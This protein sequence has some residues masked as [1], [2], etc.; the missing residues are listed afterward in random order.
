MFPQLVAGPIVRYHTVADQ[1]QHRTHTIP[2]FAAGAQLFMIGFAKKVLLA[3]NAAYLADR[4]F[5]LAS[6]DHLASPGLLGAWTGISA[7]AVQIYFDFSGYS[8]MA[9]GLGL[10]LGFRFPKNFD[11]P[12]KSCSVTET[13]Q[14]WHIS[15]SSWLRD[16]LYIPLGGNRH[17]ELRTYG[18]LVLTMLLGGLWHGALWTKVMWGAYNGILLASERLSGRRPVYH[19]LPRPARMAMTFLIW[20]VGLTIFR[21]ESLDS[22][23][24]V[25]AGM[26]G[27]AG[28]GVWLTC[29]LHTEFAYAALLLGL[30]IAFAAPQS[31]DIVRRYRTSSMLWINAAFVLALLQVMSRSHSP[32][33][34]FQF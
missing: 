34:Y 20:L 19:R 8:D 4:V 26:V 33:I 3:D 25:Y 29:A 1:I 10:M 9:I 24:S 15:L 18:N 2:K 13:W 17:G 30:V 7:Y 21:A 31:W 6:P 11:S 16:Y 23:G 5:A 28:G 22:L 32:F 12:Y 27:A 14:R